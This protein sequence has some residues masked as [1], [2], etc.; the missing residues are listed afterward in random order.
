MSGTDGKDK[1]GLPPSTRPEDPPDPGAFDG[2]LAR[3]VRTAPVPLREF[4][5]L[6]P[7]DERLEAALSMTPP[8]IVPGTHV[9][10][11]L[12][13]P[14]FPPLLGLVSIVPRSKGTIEDDAAPLPKGRAVKVRI[15]RISAMTSENEEVVKGAAATGMPVV[16]GEGTD[17]RLVAVYM[18]VVVRSF[19]DDTVVVDLCCGP[20]RSSED[21]AAWQRK[22][23]RNEGERQQQIVE[24]LTCIF[25]RVVLQIGLVVRFMGGPPM[26]K[27]FAALH[28]Y[29]AWLGDDRA[30][31]KVGIDDSM[32]GSATEL[33]ETFHTEVAMSAWWAWVFFFTDRPKYRAYRFIEAR[34][35]TR[36]A[37]GGVQVKEEPKALSRTELARVLAKAGALAAPAVSSLASIAWGADAQAAVKLQ[38]AGS[39]PIR[40]TVM[41]THY[42]TT[43]PSSG[44]S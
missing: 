31:T 39:R 8:S 23:R 16:V 37:V 2:D 36:R 6:P 1:N 18:A 42:D 7:P 28:G 3:P 43:E 44:E 9:V 13:P 34:N 11:P 19:S 26:N 22:L 27:E 24:A 14:A 21:F 10:G 5:P 41:L 35:A 29:H 30:S 40:E 33:A 15:G 4:R 17:R 12:R 20:F 25:G 32:V 38:A